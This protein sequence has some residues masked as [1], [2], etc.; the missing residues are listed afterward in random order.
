MRPIRMLACAAALL[1]A[2]ADANAT[3]QLF[4]AVPGIAGDAIF[5]GATNEIQGVSY[6]FGISPLKPT[7]YGTAGVCAPGSFKPVFSEFCVVKRADVASPK[8]FV[9]AATATQFA[10]VVVR[11]FRSGALANDPPL[12]RYD[13]AN[14]LVSSLQAEADTTAD[15]PTER[16]CF[17]FNRAT[18]TTSRAQQGGG[19]ATETAG[20]DACQ[21]S[22]F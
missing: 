15:G 1:V 6:D 7:K 22:P 11:V 18:V 10:T 17:R 20:F 3:T 12:V 2:G 16:V 9:A 8:L 4:V 13:L 19:F 14:A 21:S 5:E